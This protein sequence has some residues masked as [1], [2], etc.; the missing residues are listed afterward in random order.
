MMGEMND[1]FGL[2]I[3]DY[4]GRTMDDFKSLDAIITHLTQKS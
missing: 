1:H 3:N 2:S 4:K